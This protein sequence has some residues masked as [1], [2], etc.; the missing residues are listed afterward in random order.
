MS[1]VV[2]SDG[3]SIAFDWTGSG[4]PVILVDGAFCHR[5]L[6]PAP[7]LV[8]LLSSHFTVFS[9]DR[10]G[11]GES[12]D[13][14]PY[15]VEREIDDLAVLIG[16]AGGSAYVLGMSSG[17][18]LGVR[19]A[20]AGLGIGKLALYEPPF[21]AVDAR[22]AAPPANAGEV[23]QALVDKG[24]PGRAA[25]YFLTSVMGMPAPVVTLMSLVPGLW[26]K[27]KASA[28]SLPHEIA[29]MGDWTVPTDDLNSIKVPAVVISGE[30]SPQK[31]RAAAQAVADA[32]PAIRH[33]VLAGQSHN[34]SMAVLAPVVINFFGS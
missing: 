9:Y 4:P 7:K 34:V 27:T 23:L 30:K 25:R 14:A 15:S 11:R 26:S 16:E 13:T 12:T 1:K 24:Q 28:G 19:A 32:D 21:T 22:H 6:G 31:L 10:R 29:V 20:A 3:T 8:P 18:A 17:A 33:E 5:K 2:A